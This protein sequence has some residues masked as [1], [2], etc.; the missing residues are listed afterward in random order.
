[1]KKTPTLQ[2][3]FFNPR[4]LLAFVLCSIGVIIALFGLGAFPGSSALAQDPNSTD[5]ASKDQYRVGM[6]SAYAVYHDVSPPMR[7]VLPWPV[8]AK[9]R[10][11][12]ANLNP[13]IPHNHVDVPDPVVQNAQ[14]SMLARLT[15]LIP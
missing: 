3:A 11:R 7:S 5:A 6:M 8:H 14:A 9:E 1:M 4:V 13:S 10:E 2:S 15:P 12:E